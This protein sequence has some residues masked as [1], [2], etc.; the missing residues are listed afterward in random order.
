MTDITRQKHWVISRTVTTCLYWNIHHISSW[1]RNNQQVEKENM[2]KIRNILCVFSI[3]GQHLDV[4]FSCC[5]PRGS[6]DG[7]KGTHKCPYWAFPQLQRI[8]S[9]QMRESK[10]SPNKV[11]I[12]DSNLTSESNQ[13]NPQ[14][15]N[16]SLELIF[17]TLADLRRW[18]QCKEDK[19]NPTSYIREQGEEGGL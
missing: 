9:R 8:T 6:L 16:Q 18:D 4:V 5:D 3:P 19:G 2:Y 12:S 17:W 10:P 11:R 15:W 14:I 7:D 13:T 1:I